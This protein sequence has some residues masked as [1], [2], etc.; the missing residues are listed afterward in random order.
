LTLRIFSREA[1]T[2]SKIHRLLPPLRGSFRGSGLDLRADTRSYVLSPLTRL[3][4]RTFK[5]VGEG[6]RGRALRTE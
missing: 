2:A 3:E 1:A 5:I 4:A 6:P